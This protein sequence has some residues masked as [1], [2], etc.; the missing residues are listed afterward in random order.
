MYQRKRVQ[1]L[2]FWSASKTSSC[3]LII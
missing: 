3:I 1:I 2:N